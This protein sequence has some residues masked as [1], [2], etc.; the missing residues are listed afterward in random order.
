VLSC[1]VRNIHESIIAFRRLAEAIGP[2]ETAPGASLRTPRTAQCRGMRGGSLSSMAL[3]RL[4]W[5]ESAVSRRVNRSGSAA[6]LARAAAILAATPGLRTPESSLAT[7]G[8]AHR[9]VRDGMGRAP[10]ER[11]ATPGNTGMRFKEP[12]PGTEQAVYSTDK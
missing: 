12:P 2:D 5:I 10:D 8:N 3:R 7:G 11:P 1:I 6:I 9:S 4:G